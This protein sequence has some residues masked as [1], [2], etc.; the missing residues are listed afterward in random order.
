MIIAWIPARKGSRRLPH[1]NQKKIGS[2]SLV[3]LAV[4]QARAAGFF[5]E[6]FVDTD[7]SAIESDAIRAGA[8]S[9]GLRPR[10]VSRSTTSTAESLLS[11]LDR[12][13]A[14]L[15]VCEVFVLQP[16]SP[17]R[18]AADITNFRGKLSHSTNSAASCSPPWQ[19]SQDLI[20]LVG[21]SWRTP[22]DGAGQVSRRLLFLDGAIFYCRTEWLLK[23]EELVVAGET[24]II[25][26]S[27]LAGLDIDDE[28]QLRVARAISAYDAP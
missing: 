27:R 15:A 28:F 8:K 11:W 18:S 25:E 22:F 14:D 5:D 23:K 19:P 10:E 12:L 20:E 17:L 24:E 21:K 16:S 6:I 13:P 4:T 3:S 7:S 1:K 2:Q 9:I 26:I